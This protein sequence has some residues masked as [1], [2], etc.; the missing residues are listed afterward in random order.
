MS[1]PCF[2]LD[3]SWTSLEFRSTISNYGTP[4]S[5][6]IQRWMTSFISREDD[7]SILPRRAAKASPDEGRY[8][9]EGVQYGECERSNLCYML[10][11]ANLSVR[12]CIRT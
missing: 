7:A 11:K 10:F 5:C 9:R 12:E 8:Q 1:P 3:F 6:T 4:V 2:V